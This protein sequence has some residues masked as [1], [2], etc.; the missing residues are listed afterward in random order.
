MSRL[1]QTLAGSCLLAF[2]SLASAAFHTW[3]IAEIYSNADGTIQFV[4]LRESQAADVENLL[5]GRTLT[6]TRAGGAA[7]TFVFPN[8]LPSP[9]TA[10]RYVLIAT[11][12]YVDASAAFSE[13]RAAMPDYVIPNQFLPTDGGTVNY[14]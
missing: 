3:Q 1:I 7:K 5:A 10:N 4:Q 8:D 11:Q 12:G 6:A 2:A 14:A 13:F 9:F